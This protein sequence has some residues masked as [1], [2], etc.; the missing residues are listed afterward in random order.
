MGCASSKA[1]TA[2]RDEA[3]EAGAP[4]F[5]PVQQSP[6]RPQSP[7]QPSPPPANVQLQHSNVVPPQPAW[8]PT[9]GDAALALWL[10]SR[11][12]QCEVNEANPGHAW[13]T[14]CYNRYAATSRTTLCAI[15]M[16]GPLSP[17]HELC[18]ACYA[19]QEGEDDEGSSEVSDDGGGT[20]LLG[21]LWPLLGGGGDDGGWRRAGQSA[22]SAS[23]M[24]G[25]RLANGSV[26]TVVGVGGGDGCLTR[27]QLAALP[28]RK[29]LGESDALQDDMACCTICQIEYEEGDEL[30][31]LPACSHTFHAACVGE[32]LFKKSATCPLC[33]RDVREDLRLAA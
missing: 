13:C 27:Q 30:H 5:Q 26:A 6:R 16:T 31:M 32:W 18:R 24:N 33:L 20:G 28:C 4:A 8:D 1:P 9:A 14:Q 22:S 2:S 29:F 10:A 12:S 7:P 11:C 17:G 23:T 21:H 25:A 15:C 3:G 19:A